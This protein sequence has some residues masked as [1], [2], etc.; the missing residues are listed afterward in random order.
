MR[1]A[2]EK[3]SS[4]AAL[5]LLGSFLEMLVPKPVPF[6]RIGLANIPIMLSISTLG[7]KDYFILLMLKAVASSYISGTIFTYFFLISLSQ[8]MLSGLVMY[9]LGR[10]QKK[11]ISYYG[12]SLSGAFTGTIVQIFTASLYMG[13]GIFMLLTPFLAS[14]FVFA[15]VTAYLAGSFSWITIRDDELSQQTIQ[16]SS[17]DI[18][19]VLGALFSVLSVQMTDNPAILFMLFCVLI[20]LLPIYKRRIRITPYLMLFLISLSSNLIIKRGMVVATVFGFEITADSLAL[21]IERALKLSSTVAL[22]LI[23]SKM[24]RAPGLIGKTL[25]KF[26]FFE[27]QL[28]NTKGSLK[29][30]ISSALSCPYGEMEGVHME[31]SIIKAMVPL[32]ICALCFIYSL[33]R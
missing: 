15:L 20:L 6:F 30:R 1:S 13:R 17:K 11:R 18:L 31:T 10:T 32:A 21:A 33:L 24:M 4:Y 22:S 7:F 5:C 23:Y 3:I 29:E 26:F 2:T 27:D 25:S 16:Y 12:I 8:S 9:L 28:Q 14:S 19:I